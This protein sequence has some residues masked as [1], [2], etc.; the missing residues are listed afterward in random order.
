MSEIEEKLRPFLCKLA[1]EAA[2][3]ALEEAAKIAERW[4][5][6][7]NIDQNSPDA[8]GCNAALNEGLECT[9][10]AGIAA[11]IRKIKDRLTANPIQ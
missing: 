10:P 8:T 9:A 7:E 11:E 1:N 2:I 4:V 3:A 6:P 5:D